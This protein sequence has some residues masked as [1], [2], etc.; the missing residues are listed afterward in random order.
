MNNKNSTIKL[1]LLLL[2]PLVVYFPLIG[3]IAVNPDAY[4]TLPELMEVQNPL[5]YFRNLTHFNVIDFQPVRDMTFFLDLLFFRLTGIIT[6]ATTN[7][8]LW[9]LG[10][11]LL[12]K[13][14]K[15]NV[16]DQGSIDAHYWVIFFLCFPLF[17]QVV[18]WGM[19]RKHILAFVLILGATLNYMDW[20]DGKR[21]WIGAYL[22]YVASCL[23][24]PLV[25]LWPIWA[26]AHAK[27][28][29]PRMPDD[30]RKVHSAFALTGITILL[31]NYAYYSVG[32]AVVAQNFW[33]LKP[34]YLNL[35]RLL[36]TLSFA[37]RQM[38]FPFKLSFLYHPIWE[39]AWPGLIV[40]TFLCLYLYRTR[41]EWKHFS[42][43]LFG[44]LS[45][46]ITFTLPNFFD[47][48]ILLPF[49]GVFILLYKRFHRPSRKKRMALILLAIGL[50]PVT[51]LNA[52]IWQSEEKFA[53]TKK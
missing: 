21:K 32:N 47:Q 18:P 42:W 38:I 37:F 36:L 30:S 22:L 12:L 2:V 44:F 17:S 16:P 5:D 35:P 29:G 27:L 28:N 34:D 24:H 50:A 33:K 31:T 8:F 52:R 41:Y 46:P 14:L 13:I 10:G 39:N 4:L 45:I 15:R 3:R 26:Y 53:E 9:C 25:V 6:F 40:I 1:L 20:L 43:L 48:Y 7:I 19:G 11:F 23:S 49:T 51:F